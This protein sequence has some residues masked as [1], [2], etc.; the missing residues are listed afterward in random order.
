MPNP[1]TKPRK[2]TQPPIRNSRELT[3]AIVVCLPTYL[4]RGDIKV[5][6]S[7]VIAECE[8]RASSLVIDQ[9]IHEYFKPLMKHY[10]LAIS[11][12]G[13]RVDNDRVLRGRLKYMDHG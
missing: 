5:D 9:I 7:N 1:K 4:E 10:G 2:K 8:I 13:L 11:K 6:L 12:V 3:D